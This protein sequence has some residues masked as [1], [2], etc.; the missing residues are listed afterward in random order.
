LVN[1]SC[2]SPVSDRFSAERQHFGQERERFGEESEQLERA[3]EE[4][5]AVL[6]GAYIF[7]CLFISISICTYI[8]AGEST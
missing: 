7:I 2:I 8:A 6:Q 3:H 4:A 5:V 1:S